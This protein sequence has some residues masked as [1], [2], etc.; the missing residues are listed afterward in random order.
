MW[1]EPIGTEE[2]KKRHQGER[3]LSRNVKDWETGF[4]KLKKDERYAKVHELHRNRTKRSRAW[5]F[6]RGPKKEGKSQAVR[7][8]EIIIGHTDL[9]SKKI[10]IADREETLFLK[11][12]EKLE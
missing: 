8:G 10:F 1:T 11:D 9:V 7:K 5:R 6:K 2:E 3:S 4:R 12:K